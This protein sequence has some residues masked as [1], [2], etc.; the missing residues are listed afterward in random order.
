MKIT[1]A[2]AKFC[3]AM[4]ADTHMLLACSTS[5]A[6]ETDEDMEDRRAFIRLY[7]KKKH[8]EMKAKLAQLTVAADSHENCNKELDN[9]DE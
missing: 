2:D 9:D 3:T 7:R 8:A 5:V 4:L 1:A 6:G